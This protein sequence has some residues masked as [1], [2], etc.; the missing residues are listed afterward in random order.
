M[1]LG[2][3][4]APKCTHPLIPSVRNQ[5]LL[6][7]CISVCRRVGVPSA[8]PVYVQI[9]RADSGWWTRSLVVKKPVGIPKKTQVSLTVSS[10]YFGILFFSCSSNF[11]SYSFSSFHLFVW[12]SSYRFFILFL[13]LPLSFPQLS[14]TPSLTFP[15]VLNFLFF[16]VIRTI[17]YETL[18][19]ISIVCREERRRQMAESNPVFLNLCET[20]AR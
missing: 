19:T 10:E 20:V 11:S 1:R 3:A 13:F 17:L 16:F 15:I 8:D 7:T 9:H 2:V 6:P 14:D 12:S 4:A 5:K 18:S